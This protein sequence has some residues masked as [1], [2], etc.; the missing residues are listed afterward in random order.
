MPIQMN[1]Y[2]LGQSVYWEAH[3]S[4]QVKAG[5]GKVDAIYLSMN[6][7]MIYRVA[8][9]R[10]G[11]PVLLREGELIAFTDEAGLDAPAG[12]TG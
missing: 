5:R 4:H 12:A 9:D 2:F 3:P 1:K 8:P 10:P 7:E 6:D 11:I